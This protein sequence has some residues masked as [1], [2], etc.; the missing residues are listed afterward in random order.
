METIKLLINVVDNMV[1]TKTENMIA[2]NVGDNEVTE[3]IVTAPTTGVWAGL[4]LGIHFKSPKGERPDEMNLGVDNNI[5]IP[6]AVLDAAGDLKFSIVGRNLDGTEVIHTNDKTMKVLAALSDY[7]HTTPAAYGTVVTD[8]ISATAASIAQTGLCQTATASAVEIVE[9]VQGKLDNGDFVG[10][11]GATGPNS[12]STSTATNI[13]GL[14]AGDGTH[15]ST[16]TA[17]QV[18]ALP[19]P[20]AGNYYTD[21]TVNGALQGVGARLSQIAS[22]GWVTPIRTSFVNQSANLFNRYDSNLVDGG[23]LKYG[24]AVQVDALCFYTGKI[25][26]IAGE[27]YIL[28]TDSYFADNTMGCYYSASDV[29]V[30][31]VVTTAAGGYRSF[32]VP[33][34]TGLSYMRI[35]MRISKKA[36]MMVVKNTVYPPYYTAFNKS[37][38]SEFVYSPLFG[39]IILWD[40]DSIMYGVGFAGGFANIIAGNNSMISTNYAISG[41]SI[42][43][44]AADRHCV[45]RNI[46]S[47]SATADYVVFEGGV[48]DYS[49]SV[50][51]GAVTSGWTDALDDTTFCGALESMCKQAVLKWPGKKIGYVNVHK[52]NGLSSNFQTVWY[53]KMIEI[54]NKWG[55]SF[56][57]LNKDMPSLNLIAD[58]KTAY[59]KDADGWHPT[60]TAYRAWYVPKITKWLETL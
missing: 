56:C 34:L 32:T 37:L 15:I 10:A 41:G 60:E 52:I 49:L 57:D 25:P 8:C 21:K 48:N 26:V 6:G 59:T 33:T 16:P 2:G 43:Y 3:I 42:A 54:C 29:A 28:P 46:S 4:H 36:T 17:A 13:T 35:N 27:Q 7:G 58:L 19:I 11:T 55:V 23:Y 14:L 24:G 39:K 31:K 50:A 44:V 22:D 47:M 53:P 9:T 20:D 45:A 30:D 18:G 40:G 5:K 12:V 51:L 1:T 38:D